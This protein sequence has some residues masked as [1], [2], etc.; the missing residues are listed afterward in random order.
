MLTVDD[1][2]GEGGVGVDDDEP[3]V[4]LA[5][6]STEGTSLNGGVWFIVISQVPSYKR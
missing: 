6:L 4:R 2:E 1:G 5:L 3:A